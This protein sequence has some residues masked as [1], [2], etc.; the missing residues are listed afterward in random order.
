MDK[1][2]NKPTYTDLFTDQERETF[3]LVMKP[4]LGDNPDPKTVETLHYI[5]AELQAL[6][7]QM[8]LQSTIQF[9]QEIE[10]NLKTFDG[11]TFLRGFASK[12]PQHQQQIEGVFQ[13]A[14]RNATNFHALNVENN[15]ALDG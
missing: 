7:T 12:L 8:V 3:L 6:N 10:V 1:G 2:N 5:I 9:F 11:A 15:P 14:K 13:I 4:I